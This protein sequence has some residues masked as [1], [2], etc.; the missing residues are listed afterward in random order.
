MDNPFNQLSDMCE[1]LDVIGKGLA[2]VIV[3]Q[4]DIIIAV[5]KIIDSS[6][7]LDE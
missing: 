6:C 7:I 5:E 1:Q 3:K 2:D 4:K